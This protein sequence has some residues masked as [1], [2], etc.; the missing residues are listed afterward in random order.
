MLYE[1]SPNMQEVI[2]DLAT[3]ATTADIKRFI[4]LIFDSVMTH[5]A[6]FLDII[7]V[8]IIALSPIMNS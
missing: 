2:F 5:L 3:L 1:H 4:Y 7:M 6:L 8:F